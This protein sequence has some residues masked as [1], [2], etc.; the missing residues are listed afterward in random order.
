VCLSYCHW[1]L[2]YIIL[3]GWWAAGMRA[4]LLAIHVACLLLLLLLQETLREEFADR[5]LLAVAHRL[6]TI[7]EADRVLVMQQGSAVEYGAPG[8]LLKDPSGHFT[9][10]TTCPVDAHTAVH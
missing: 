10:A 1:G 8:A 3:G 6:H 4:F 2:E 5:T 9:G 7:I